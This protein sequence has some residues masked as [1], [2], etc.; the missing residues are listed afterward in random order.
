M[1]DTAQLSD[2]FCQSSY[3]CNLGTSPPIVLAAN[4]GSKGDWARVCLWRGSGRGFQLPCVE[5]MLLRVV[6]GWVDEVGV[7]SMWCLRNSVLF[8][9]SRYGVIVLSSIVVVVFV[10]VLEFTFCYSS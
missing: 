10:V 6:M 5:T 1:N 2:I 7:S 4:A 3:F 9:T 8:R